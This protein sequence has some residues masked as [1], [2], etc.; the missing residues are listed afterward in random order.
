LTAALTFLAI[1]A[2]VW[3]IGQLTSL[4]LMIFLAL[5]LS[6]A[7]IPAVDWLEKRG[8]ERRWAT[9]VV[10][11]SA[12]FLILLFLATL[13]PLFI[14][15][16]AAIAVQFPNYLVATEEWLN[17]F[18]DVDLLDNQVRSQ[19]ED[20]GSLLRRHGTQVAGGV[21]AVGT[22]FANVAFQTVT[23]LLFAFYMVAETPKMLR[24]VLSFFPAR[25]QRLLL[26]IW[27]VSIE[28][29]GGYVYSRLILSAISAV[30]T[31]VGLALLSV[32]Y[33]VA[34]GI[35]VG[36]MSQLIPVIGTFI[37]GTLPVFIA[38]IE[39]PIT[40]L[41]VI[42]L[43]IAYQQVENLVIS[44]RV[45]ARTMAIHP[46]VSVG[47]VIA[48]GSLLGAVGTVLSLPVA[49][50]VQSLIS[51]TRQRHDLVEGFE[52]NDEQDGPRE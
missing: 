7:L 4:L 12:L 49:A 16:T 32:P 43:I 38:L 9:V 37:A 27:R 5:F 35:W 30:I 13:L 36:V 34:L 23:S 29:T 3:V 31:A 24:L 2:T 44:P 20:L 45:T 18:I 48:G 10:F 46:A 39:N 28:K 41:W 1:V 22:T 15:Q 21:L 50:I 25:R 52:H 26:Q 8:W 47:A 42:I 11:A 33:P 6:V 40:A 51:T 17:N 19:F 14:N